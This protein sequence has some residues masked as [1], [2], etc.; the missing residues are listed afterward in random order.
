MKLVTFERELDSCQHCAGCDQVLTHSPY[1]DGVIGYD[2]YCCDKEC[3]HL[4]RADEILNSWKKTLSEQ[5]CKIVDS[6]GGPEDE[7]PLQVTVTRD[8]LRSLMAVLTAARRAKI[9]RDDMK[10]LLG[11]VDREIERFSY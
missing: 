8:D 3:Y 11:A 5:W 7:E 6:G 1:K 4:G 9:L 2:G 10:S